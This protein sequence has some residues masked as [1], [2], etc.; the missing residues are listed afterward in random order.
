MPK[1]LKLFIRNLKSKQALSCHNQT[2]ELRKSKGITAITYIRHFG[3][4]R[5][6]NTIHLKW[7]VTETV[8]HSTDVNERVCTTYTCQGSISRAVSDP[9]NNKHGIVRKN[10]PGWSNAQYQPRWQWSQTTGIQT[11]FWQLW[12]GAIEQVIEFRLYIL[13]NVYYVRSCPKFF[14][15]ILLY[16]PLFSQNQDLPNSPIYHIY[17]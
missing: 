1:I 13:I 3:F 4:L 9:G 14:F 15:W 8:N 7:E 2:L 5:N 11:F 6:G 12:L 17:S 16:K 10:G